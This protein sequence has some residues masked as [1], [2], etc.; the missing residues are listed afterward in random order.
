MNWRD[1]GIS[2]SVAEVASWFDG[3]RTDPHAIDACGAD[4]AECIAE[5]SAY[6]RDCDDWPF[7]VG[8][9]DG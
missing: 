7:G 2:D 5:E 6:D 8:V 9:I 1:E 4:C 3:V